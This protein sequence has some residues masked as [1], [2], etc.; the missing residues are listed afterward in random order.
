MVYHVLYGSVDIWFINVYFSIM[1]VISYQSIGFDYFYIDH[2]FW[3]YVQLVIYLFISNLNL[4]MLVK[5][6]MEEKKCHPWTE[7]REGIVLI[8]ICNYINPN[9][10]MT[11]VIY[12]RTIC[13]ICL[14][15]FV[16]N[17]KIRINIFIYENKHLML[18]DNTM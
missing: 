12:Y 13:F 5:P 2:S 1:N 9:L 10:V 4:Q 14:N 6:Y 8:L 11:I 17:L 7:L 16:E 18:S 15:Q 3:L